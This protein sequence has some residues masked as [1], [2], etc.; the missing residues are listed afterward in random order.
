MAHIRSFAEIV[1]T[2]EAEKALIAACR[3]G[4]PC[5]LGDG[6]RPEAGSDG[7]TIRAELLRY[8]LFGGCREC[9]VPDG[10]RLTGAYVSGQLDL[11]FR[12]V[13]CQIGLMN[14]RF[15]EAPQ[16]LQTRCEILSLG[17]SA[18]PGMN[19]QGIDVK[20]DVFLRK[21]FHATGEFRL[22]GAVIGGQLICVNG[23]FDNPSGDALN[24]EGINVRGD[25]FLHKFHATG[26]VSLARS[27]VG[28]QLALV[29]CR[30]DDPSV[31]A[32]NF[33]SID[34]KGDF[35]WRG[36]LVSSGTVSL[37]AVHV[38]VL[39]DDQSWPEGERLYLDGF[40][41]DR[42]SNAP[43]DAK[44]RLEWLRRG[45][46][47]NGAFFP[48]PYV[49]LAK[50]L[51][52]M[53]HDRDARDVLIEMRWRKSRHERQRAHSA[54]DGSWRAGFNSIGADL[55]RLWGIVLH[56]SVGYGLKPMR[57]AV[58]LFALFLFATFLANKTWTEG[59]FAPN[60]GPIIASEAW[61]GYATDSAIKNPATTW[62]A[63]GR[64]GQDWESFNALA[65][66]ADVVIPIIDFGQTSAWAPSTTRGGWGWHLWW[67]RW[68]LGA[69]GWIVSALGA[70]AVTGIIRRD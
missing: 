51:R 62:S 24:A 70:A 31:Y 61:Q 16:F 57:S 35:I 28:R 60:S 46:Y 55:S 48:Q 65:Y 25:V 34:I 66:G 69:L 41:Y 22:S 37:A 8:L 10:V 58:I 67:A 54:L 3:A 68:V 18:L 43:T 5:K 17:G 11:S 45:T 56:W 44:S 7:R 15:E 42:I 6:E 29:Q 14:C 49:Q 36:V 4:E 33:E 19:A 27:V 47:W 39:S 32:L 63:K 64:A 30:F 20:G 21:G 53:G 2:T 40:T 1:E 12:R 52:A 50:T 9:E 13:D 23:W 59:S 38:G 26:K